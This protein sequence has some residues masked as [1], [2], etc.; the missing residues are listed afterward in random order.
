MNEI[1]RSVD[2]G[3]DGLRGAAPAARRKGLHLSPAR[4]PTAPA[5][6]T[7]WASPVRATSGSR[8]SS[9]SARCSPKTPREPD[10]QQLV[11]LTVAGAVPLPTGAHAVETAGGKR[12]SIGFV[13]SSYFSPTLD[14]PIALGL[15]ERGAERMGEEIAFVH[16]GKTMRAVITPA[17]RLRRRKERASM[18]EPL[19]DRSKFWTASPDWATAEIRRDGLAHAVGCSASA[20]SW[21]AAGSPARSR[22]WRRARRKPACGASWL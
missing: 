9:A 7:T 6:R 14:R 5:C 19:S 1:A 22:R 16:L 3:A 20:R 2:G 13:T 15:I 11:G 21:S 10:R 12:R 18:A 17:L 8:N 4:T